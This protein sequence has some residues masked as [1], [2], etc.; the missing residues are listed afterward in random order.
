LIDV[1]IIWTYF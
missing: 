1:G